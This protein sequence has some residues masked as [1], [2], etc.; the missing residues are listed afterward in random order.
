MIP[1]GADTKT[2]ISTRKDF[3]KPISSYPTFTMGQSAVLSKAYSLD[4]EV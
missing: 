3:G 2:Q 1:E 4:N